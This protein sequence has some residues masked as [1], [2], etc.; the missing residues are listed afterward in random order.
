VSDPIE[1]FLRHYPGDG[2]T[3]EEYDALLLEA[4]AYRENEQR[5]ER[6]A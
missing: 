6:A 5:E 1:D 4:E 3:A 2:K